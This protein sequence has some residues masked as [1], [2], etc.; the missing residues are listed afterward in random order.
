MIQVFT[1]AICLQVLSARADVKG[2]LVLTRV[3]F[4]HHRHFPWP[5]VAR[6]AAVAFFAG[7]ASMAA[8][9]RLFRRFAEKIAVIVGT[10]WTFIVA[11]LV[12]IGWGASGPLFGFS[13]H[14]QLVVN[15]FTTIVTFLMVFVI[16]N[17]Q[18]R[19][20]Q[21]LQLKLD[22]LLRTTPGAHR[23]TINLQEL[24]DDELHRLERAYQQLREKPGATSEHIIDEISRSPEKQPQR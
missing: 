4:A 15:S 21:A 14:W 2:F 5:A 19:D 1:A 16:Q 9:N 17:T 8:M 11:L 7:A 23:G 10:P 20:F 24:T 3:A 6:A 12:L 22:E 18:N 13:E